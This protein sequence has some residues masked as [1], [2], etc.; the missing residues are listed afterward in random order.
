MVSMARRSSF[1]L[2]LSV[3]HTVCESKITVFDGL[4]DR[5][6]VQRDV[7]AYYK[8]NDEKNSSYEFPTSEHAF[9]YNDLFASWKK[10]ADNFCLALKQIPHLDASLE[11]AFWFFQ[12]LEDLNFRKTEP[13]QGADKNNNTNS[14]SATVT[15]VATGVKCEAEVGNPS[16]KRLDEVLTAEPV[17]YE[18]LYYAVAALSLKSTATKRKKTKKLRAVLE[19]LLDNFESGRVFETLVHK[20][21]ATSNVSVS[22]NLL[23]VTK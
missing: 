15:T 12:T 16:V 20:K 5:A 7:R 14:K 23:K 9:V 17:I 11:S 2:L 10:D 6:L 21:G 22:S 1:L 3:V 18:D 13:G 8:S 19:T 4:L